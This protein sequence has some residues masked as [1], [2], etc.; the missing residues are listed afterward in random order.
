[1]FVRFS[2]YLNRK[3]G[4]AENSAPFPDDSELLPELDKLGC[5]V[6]PRLLPSGEFATLYTTELVEKGTVATVG[7]ILHHRDLAVRNGRH[8]EHSKTEKELEKY[9]IYYGVQSSFE[10][11]VFVSRVSGDCLNFTVF[12]KNVSRLH[13]CM[14]RFLHSV[15][16][17]SFVDE[18]RTIGSPVF[19][20]SSG[21]GLEVGSGKVV[22]RSLRSLTALHKIE[23][24][25]LL[26]SAIGLFV[27]LVISNIPN[28]E[29]QGAGSAL[30][31]TSEEIMKGFLG[32]FLG[33]LVTLIAQY[34]TMDRTFVAY[35]KGL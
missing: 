28:T 15:L 4:T 31:S 33:A 20:F 35:H 12:Q 23:V 27:F 26:L 21:A 3:T 30:I 25:I 17:L 32:A 29:S 8:L 6:R 19:I 10:A 9:G 34:M 14:K 16:E 2:V 1:M 24:S 13:E 5:N 22:Q 18:K 11:M 7:T